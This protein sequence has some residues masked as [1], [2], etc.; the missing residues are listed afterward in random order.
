[1]FY[2]IERFVTLHPDKAQMRYAGKL[3][4]C[5]CHG[6]VF[7]PTSSSGDPTYMEHW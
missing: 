5:V 6:R 7:M 4:L 2:E 3:M 1:M